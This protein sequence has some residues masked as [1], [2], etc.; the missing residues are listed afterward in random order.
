MQSSRIVSD[1]P[2]ADGRRDITEEHTLNSGARVRVNYL[3][4]KV[5]DALARLAASATEIDAQEADEASTRA[6]ITLFL[7]MRSKTN[8]YLAGLTNL[9]L[10][11]QVGL[12]NPEIVVFRAI[13]NN[14][15]F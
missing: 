12:S 15:G 10:S 13:S 7:S 3:A 5:W 2:Q 9:Q 1:V 8:A 11:Q 6:G 4:P 14:G